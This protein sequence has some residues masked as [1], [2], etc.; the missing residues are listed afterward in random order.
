MCT[1]SMDL[2]LFYFFASL[3][4]YRGNPSRALSKFVSMRMHS[5]G[6][7]EIWMTRDMYRNR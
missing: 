4:E 1:C 2:F 3:G 7:P 5:L 6:R